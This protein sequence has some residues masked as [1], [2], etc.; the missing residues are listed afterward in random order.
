MKLV[1]M[2]HDGM[3]QMIP[4]NC[5]KSRRKNQA[6]RRLQ[7]K[8]ENV[9]M[10]NC[11]IR[12]LNRS[13]PRQF[14]RLAARRTYFPQS[15]QSGQGQHFDIGNDQRQTQRTI[16]VTFCIQYII[17][18]FFNFYFHFAF[19]YAIISWLG[20]VT[21]TQFAST[22]RLPTTKSR[23]QTNKEKMYSTCNVQCLVTR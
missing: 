6:I 16:A 22:S 10:E 3:K 20:T 9:F 2:S 1:M 18:Y 14:S 23:E 5:R 15:V 11:V 12:F 4:T 21:H 7:K 19:T 17:I 13:T 8:I